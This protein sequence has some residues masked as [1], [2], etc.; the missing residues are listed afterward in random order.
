MSF[1]FICLKNNLPEG[2]AGDDKLDE[3]ENVGEEDDDQDGHYHAPLRLV[4]LAL[5]QILHGENIHIFWG[6]GTKKLGRFF[7]TRQLFTL[8]NST[9]RYTYCTVT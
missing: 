8:F 7:T 9:V 5:Q 3:E 2:G 6:L 4:L 1:L